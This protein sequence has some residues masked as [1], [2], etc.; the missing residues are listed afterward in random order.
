MRFISGSECCRRRCARS[1][2]QMPNPVKP[3]REAEAARSRSENGLNSRSVC[4]SAAPQIVQYD[5][6]SSGEFMVGTVR[7]SGHVAIAQ[8]AAVAGPVRAHGGDVV[9]AQ[10]GGGLAWVEL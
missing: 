6:S 10:C 9:F 4:G 2:C 5:A 1:A 7:P 8:V 3:A